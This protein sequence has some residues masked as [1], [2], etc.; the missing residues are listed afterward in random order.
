M[1]KMLFIIALVISMVANAQNDT[2]IVKKDVRFDKETY[3]SKSGDTKEYYYAY[4]GDECYSSNKTSYE[5]YKAY[6]RFG[7]KPTYALITNKKGKRIII[8]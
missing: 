8:L 1:K 2:T 6:K 4:I 5:R 3:T 7:I